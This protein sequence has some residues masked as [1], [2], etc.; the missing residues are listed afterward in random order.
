MFIRKVCVYIFLYIYCRLYDIVG[1]EREKLKEIYINK[2]HA[3]SLGSSSWRRARARDVCRETVSS[4]ILLLYIYILCCSFPWVGGSIREIGLSYTLIFPFFIFSFFIFL[5]QRYR[6]HILISFEKKRRSFLHI[7]FSKLL[8]FFCRGIKRWTIIL[9]VGRI[10]TDRSSFTSIC[11]V[12]MK[13]CCSSFFSVSSLS[14]LGD[15]NHE[16]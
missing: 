8:F 10:W 3:S 15:I 13:C 14:A 6:S 2:Y 5:S 16:Q 1:W 4:Y 11:D 12:A 9:H 7:F